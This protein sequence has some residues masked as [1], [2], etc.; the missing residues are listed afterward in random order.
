MLRLIFL[1]AVVGLCSASIDIE[2]LLSKMT[3]EEKCGQMTQM[4]IEG[5]QVNAEVNNPDDDTINV[6]FYLTSAQMK[7]FFDL[8]RLYDRTTK[9]R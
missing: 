1:L 3:I 9:I 8:T 7:F 4:T 2:K 6:I 5:L